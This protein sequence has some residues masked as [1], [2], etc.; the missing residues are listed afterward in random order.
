MNV[1]AITMREIH[2]RLKSPFETSFGQVPQTSGLG[3][4]VRRE[5]VDRFT[6]RTRTWKAQSARA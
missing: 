3:Y 1:E 5:I 4:R 6:A 2:M